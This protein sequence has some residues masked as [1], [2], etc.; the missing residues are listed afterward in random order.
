VAIDP[1]EIWR[2]AVE[3]RPVQETSWQVPGQLSLEEGWWLE[4]RVYGPG[5]VQGA[6]VTSSRFLLLDFV[7]LAE[8]S[9]ERVLTFAQRWGVLELCKHGFPGGSH[10]DECFLATFGQ[11]VRREYIRY[12]RGWA[13]EAGAILGAA[14]SLHDGRPAESTHW[15]VLLP[16]RT[17]DAGKYLD[18]LLGN[19]ASERRLLATKITSW[20]RHGGVGIGWEWDGASPGLTLSNR[21][22]LFGALAISLALTAG[23][24]HGLALCSACGNPYSPARK[25]QSGRAHYC[26]ACGR[27]AAWR[28]SKRRNKAKEQRA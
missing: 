15:D 6:T 4:W 21:S 17:G 2:S 7:K 8:A 26:P 1:G 5:G 10:R 11:V 9:P 18:G 25:P 19:V 13:R 22:S 24:A 14:M 12:W 3:H 23:A 16:Y 28:E 27:R 20:L